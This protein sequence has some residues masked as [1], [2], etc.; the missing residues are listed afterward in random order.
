[1]HHN[2]NSYTKEQD[3]NQSDVLIVQMN[4]QRKSFTKVGFNTFSV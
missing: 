3:K 4:F 2:I 1:M